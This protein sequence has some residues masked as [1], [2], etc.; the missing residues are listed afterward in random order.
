M[1]AQVISKMSLI[2]LLY[3]KDALIKKEEG[4]ESTEK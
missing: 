2:A 4:S 1:G 3:K